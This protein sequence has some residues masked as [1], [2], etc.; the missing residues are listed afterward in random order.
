M[1]HLLNQRWR[2]QQHQR[3]KA[4]EKRNAPR[5]ES[6]GKRSKSLGT[7]R[8]GTSIPR[9]V[10]FVFFGPILLYRRRAIANNAKRTGTG[11]RLFRELYPTLSSPTETGSLVHPLTL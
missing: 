10:F 1:G 5:K 2:F 4:S 11:D 7:E 3:P 6:L 8:R 9:A